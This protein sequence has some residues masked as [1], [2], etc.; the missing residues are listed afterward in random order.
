MYKLQ[1]ED[2]NNI[3]HENINFYTLNYYNPNIMN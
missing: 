1:F 3:K 2:E